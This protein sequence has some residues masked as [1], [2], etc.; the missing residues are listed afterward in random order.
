MW[1][2]ATPVARRFSFAAGDS[3][4]DGGALA[5][6]WTLA[7]CREHCVA[8]MPAWFGPSAAGGPASGARALSSPAA[9]RNARAFGALL[10]A[11]VEHY[12]GG[13]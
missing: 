9:L 13:R 5:S 8:A 10:C 1:A 2:D 7:A 12:A 6:A 3:Y 11:G 4:R